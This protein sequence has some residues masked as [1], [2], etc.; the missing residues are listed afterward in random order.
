MQKFQKLLSLVLALL[1]SV[2]IFTSCSDEGEEVVA[3]V[4]DYEVLYGEL[5]YLVLTQKDI[6]KSTYGDSIFDTPES[7]ALYREELERTVT[8][9]LKGNYAVLLACAQYLPSLS[10][11]SDE[12]Q[13]AVDEYLEAEIEKMGDEESYYAMSEQY[14]M[15]ESF[16]RFSY[17]VAFM[18]EALIDTLA[19]RPE[20]GELFA[21]SEAT[22]FRDWILAGNGV[23]VQHIFVRNDAGEDIDANRAIA[24]Q[25]RRE[26]MDGSLS[27]N[28]AVGSAVYNQDPSN[29][30]PYY[31][32]KGV[33]DPALE[34][35]ALPL[36][37]AGDVSAVTETDE[38]F[39]VFVRMEDPELITLGQKLSELLSSHQWSRTEEIV[40]TFRD[41]VT[42]TWTDYGKSLDWLTIS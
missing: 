18:E 24:E 15:S 31:L 38:G 3:H 11:D 2:G 26:L 32:V 17:A 33:Y 12:I 25:A 9:K 16:I 40:E 28:E 20:I 35:A 22:A 6:M 4:G 23:F 10:I 27:V 39:Y 34:S 21:D 42:F 41:D 7:A 14:Y 13:D 5:R 8:E 29:T 1:L 37:K 19:A 36:A 30:S